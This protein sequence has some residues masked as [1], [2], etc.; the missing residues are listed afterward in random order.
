MDSAR[1]LTLSLIAMLEWR[2]RDAVGDQKELARLIVGTT[3]KRFQPRQR[4]S[5]GTYVRRP[6]AEPATGVRQVWASRVQSVAI[7]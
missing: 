6:L 4:I 5:S 3:G 7:S 2:A 1:V